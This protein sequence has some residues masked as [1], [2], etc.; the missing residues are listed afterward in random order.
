MLHM[1]EG[2]T[3][4]PTLSNHWEDMT[5]KKNK[6]LSRVSGESECSLRVHA[7]FS[8]VKAWVCLTK[9]SNRDWMFPPSGNNIATNT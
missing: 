8:A 3:V 2:A 7:I 1:K 5:D 6:V 9:Y 4:T